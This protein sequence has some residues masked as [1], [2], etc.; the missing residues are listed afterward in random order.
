VSGH[1]PVYSIHIIDNG[2]VTLGVLCVDCE[3]DDAQRAQIAGRSALRKLPAVED[4]AE[5]VEFLLGDRSASHHRHRAHGPGST[6][7]NS[8]CSS[9]SLKA[10]K[11]NRDTRIVL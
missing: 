5:A 7:Y 9:P 10:D 11:G 6:V 2:R 4:V 8:D 1:S 3:D